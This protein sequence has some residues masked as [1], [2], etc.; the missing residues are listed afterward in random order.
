MEKPGIVSCGWVGILE[1]NRI[2]RPWNRCGCWRTPVSVSGNLGVH[3]WT[4]CKAAK[5]RL[6][7]RKERDSCQDDTLAF[8]S[9]FGW[10]CIR[11]KLVPG[12]SIRKRWLDG[13]WPDGVEC[14]HRTDVNIPTNSQLPTN[15]DRLPC[16]IRDANGDDSIPGNDSHP[17]ELDLQ[18]LD[19]KLHDTGPLCHTFSSTRIVFFLKT[20]QKQN[21][22]WDEKRGENTH[23]YIKEKK[24]SNSLTSFIIDIK[25]VKELFH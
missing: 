12:R 18:F 6:A 7:K 10:N 17:L 19:S 21:V 4:W 22:S 16:Y 24:N 14:R 20:K 23:T 15:M 5:P 1:D 13:K 2:A 11:M 3:I 8:Q 9:A 25:R